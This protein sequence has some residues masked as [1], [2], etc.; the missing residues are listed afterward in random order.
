MNVP[1]ITAV[2]ETSGRPDLGADLEPF[3]GS[4]G[5]DAGI[6]LMHGD[7]WHH[8][9]TV[10]EGRVEIFDA[11]HPVTVAWRFPAAGDVPGDLG[12]AD[13]GRDLETDLRRLADAGYTVKLERWQNVSGGDFYVEITNESG[14]MWNGFGASQAEAVRGIW[15]LG[16]GRGGCGHCGGLGCDVGGCAVCAAYPEVEPGECAVCT[17]G[18]AMD[19]GAPASTVTFDLTEP[20]A[21]LVLTEA[22]KAYADRQ[23]DRAAAEGGNDIRDLWARRADAMLAEVE[24]SFEGDL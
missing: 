10:A 1:N 9:R 18:G 5:A 24:Q 23:R 4:C 13:G 6:F 3:C 15:P 17:E 22:L 21:W 20:G 12:G 11:G 19:D 7:G 8:W 16:Q 14:S 2:D